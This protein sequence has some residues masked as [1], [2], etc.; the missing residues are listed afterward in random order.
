MVLFAADNIRC[1]L[2][3]LIGPALIETNGRFLVAP[4]T[5]ENFNHGSRN[6][7]AAEQCNMGI[8]FTFDIECKRVPA[9]TLSFDWTDH[10]FFI[11]SGEYF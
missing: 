1:W 4:S 9:L 10:I 11:V 6:F 8:I 3:S 5:N 7:F 2:F